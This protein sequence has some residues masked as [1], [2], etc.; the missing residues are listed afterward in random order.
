MSK[1]EVFFDYTCPFCLKGHENLVGLLPKYPGLEIEWRPCEI[2]PRPEP[3]DRHSDL[4]A[5]GMY[6]ALESGA[7]VMEYHRRIYRAAVTD[8]ADIEDLSVLSGYMEGLL[9]R[10]RF[11]Q[12]LSGDQYA[13]KL[14][15]NTRLT[16]DE[17]DFPAVPS[18]RM[19][20]D[21]LKSIPIVGVTQ[22]RLAAFLKQHTQPT[23]VYNGLI[24]A[25]R[26]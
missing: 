14:S 19:G 24:V 11:E 10:E 18:Y 9:N 17:Y 21:L 25:Q 26:K 15:E 12:A 5:R 16:W 13:D 22:K 4:C 7:D 3:C 2:H 8:H 23:R 6:F 20:E 1:L